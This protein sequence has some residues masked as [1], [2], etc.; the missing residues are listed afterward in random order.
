MEE[1]ERNAAFHEMLMENYN[2]LTK[3]EQG[4]LQKI[5][6]EKVSRFP[7]SSKKESTICTESDLSLDT[8]PSEAC[9]STFDPMTRT[10]SG[11]TT[12]T[13]KLFWQITTRQK[14]DEQM[15]EKAWEE[16]KRLR[17]KQHDKE[18]AER[19]SLVIRFAHF[20]CLCHREETKG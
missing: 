4:R 19:V 17:E 14:L 7:I 13:G 9:D 12:L 20:F 11:L 10:R 2:K 18:L 16:A 1:S 5:A 6:D 8:I 15:Q 3:I